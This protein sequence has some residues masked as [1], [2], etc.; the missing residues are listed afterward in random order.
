[1]SSIVLLFVSLYTAYADS[2]LVQDSTTYLYG[3]VRFNH[4]DLKITSKRGILTKEKVIMRNSVRILKGELEILTDFGEYFW[5]KEI[6]L[7]D[8]FVARK[9]NEVL[10][11]KTGKY[12]EDKLWVSEDVKY[13]NED[14]KLVVIGNKGFYDFDTHYGMMTQAPR[15]EAQ[16][17]TIEISGDTIE[18]FGDTLTKVFHNA[19]IKLKVTQCF[20]ESLAYLP[21][22]KYALLYGNPYIV[23]ETDSLGGEQM[24]IALSKREIKSILVKRQVWG[25]K[26]KF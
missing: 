16:Q 4:K 7:Y 25:K 24:K 6:K 1:M 8:G 10:S 19:I 23:S 13:L 20:A 22:S 3:N 26:W 15:F 5:D 14:E 17:D 11:G 21:E 2:S 9:E 12:F 18:I